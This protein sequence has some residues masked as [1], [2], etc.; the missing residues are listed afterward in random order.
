M[1]E[2]GGLA[3]R[4]LSIRSAPLLL[5]PGMS[6]FS[7]LVAV[8]ALASLAMVVT[9]ADAGAKKPKKPATSEPKAEEAP[10]PIDFDR[11]AAVS[12]I[13]EVSLQRCKVTNAAKGDGHVTIT[14][15]PGGPAE[16]ALIDKGPW[17]G[18][19]VAKCMAKEFKKVKVPAFKGEPV[20]VGK[21][22]KFE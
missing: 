3:A 8:S 6:R 20:T 17:V 13:N 11:Q 7:T 18:T 5:D 1:E 2:C 21:S 15:Q 9:S 19:P 4:V 16:K 10:A 12:A 14:F 22:F